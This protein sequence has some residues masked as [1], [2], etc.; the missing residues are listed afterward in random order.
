MEGQDSQNWTEDLKESNQWNERLSYVSMAILLG[1]YVPLTV[2]QDLPCSY[3][4]FLLSYERKQL[5]LLIIRKKQDH[6]LLPT[7]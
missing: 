7:I 3:L 6:A 1:D 5:T 2:T 4:K